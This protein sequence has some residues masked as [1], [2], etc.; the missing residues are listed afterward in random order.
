ML[1]FS[2]SIVFNGEMI[3]TNEQFRSCIEACAR[4]AEACE[5]CADECLNERDVAKMA[6]CIRLD[7]DCALMCWGAAALMSRG[8]MFAYEFCRLCAEVC[9]A[10]GAE[11]AKHNAD[12]CQRCAQECQRC[13]DEC[14]QMA[15]ARA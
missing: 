5:F 13:A 11:C 9:E 7:R 15:G 12:H 1:V 2:K 10:C 4:C 14:R 6:E 8:S 3:M